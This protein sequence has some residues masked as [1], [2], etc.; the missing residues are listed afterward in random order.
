MHAALL[1]GGVLVL[2]LFVVNMYG[3]TAL[4]PWFAASRDGITLAAHIAFGVVAAG[5][6]RVAVRRNA[7]RLGLS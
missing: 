2:A 4:F 3:F 1:A 6:Y 5:A 7:A